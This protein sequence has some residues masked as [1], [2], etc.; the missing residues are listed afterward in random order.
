MRALIT[1]ITGFAGSHLAEHLVTAGDQ[2]LGC[3]RTAAWSRDFP[4]EVAGQIQLLGWDLASGQS[5][6]VRRRVADF[7]PD[8]IFHLAALSVPADCGGEQPTPQALATNLGGT[9]AA[10]ELALS[11]SPRPKL[12]LISSCYVYAPVSPD[13]PLVDETAPVDPVGGYGETKLAAEHAVR[14]ASYDN[15]L[16]AVV[17][18]V[19]QHTGPRQSDRMIV[20]ELTRQFVAGCDPVCVTNLDTVLDLS[21]VRDIV[22]AYRCL[23]ES[24]ELGHVYNVGS[25]RAVRS[26]EIVEQ[27]RA[28][29]APE[30]RVIE[31]KPG[32]RQHP[33]ADTTRLRQATGWQPEIP[34]RQ[35][36]LDTIRYWQQACRL[37][38]RSTAVT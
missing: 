7:Q 30:R 8:W 31:S 38:T 12:L 5:A 4:P 34:L 28:L 2:V 22:R 13:H 37:P 24:G 32:H 36:I 18:R 10:I 9:S 1:G 14:S 29:I 11:L 21:D 23:A 15:G 26:G 25:G 20:P 27:L 6:A 35:T 3:S 33:I 16:E 19:F 17:A